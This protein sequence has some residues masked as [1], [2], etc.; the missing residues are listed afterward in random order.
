[1]ITFRDKLKD[2]GW[3]NA[4][5]N[6]FEN[7]FSRLFNQS[8]RGIL[9]LEGLLQESGILLSRPCFLNF[10]YENLGMTF[11]EAYHK[12]E[13]MMD[14]WSSGEEVDYWYKKYGISL[15]AISAFHIIVEFNEHMTLKAGIR[16]PDDPLEGKVFYGDIRES[17]ETVMLGFET[18]TF[19]I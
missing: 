13:S 6:A 18:N 8:N 16:N 19:T 7:H 9:S 12:A 3:S 11:L 15:Q 14:E 2:R 17:L 4:M 5:I 1:M 10:N